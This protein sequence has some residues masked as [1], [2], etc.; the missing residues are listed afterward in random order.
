MRPASIASSSGSRLSALPGSSSRRRAVEH[1]FGDGARAVD[2]LELGRLGLGSVRQIERVAGGDDQAVGI[3]AVE[4]EHRLAVQRIA[5]DANAVRLAASDLLGHA[6]AEHRLAGGDARQPLF[7][8][9]LA[10]GSRQRDRRHHRRRHVGHRRH[11]AAQRFG[12]E[13]RFEEAQANA[14]VVFGDQHGMGAEIGEAAPDL[15][16][17]RFASF[18]HGAHSVQ[19]AAGLQIA[20]DA[21]LQHPLLVVQCEVHALRSRSASGLQL[22]RFGRLRLLRQA[23]RPLADHVLLNLR[24]AAADD[25]AEVEHVAGLPETGVAQVRAAVV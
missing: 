6:D 14:A 7:L 22:R 18:G 13:R 16:G 5:L 19:C 24:G 8:L 23:E 4:H 2:G 21:V 9:A 10:A 15:V 25:E 12:D 17:A 20:G 3:H 1:R 11:R